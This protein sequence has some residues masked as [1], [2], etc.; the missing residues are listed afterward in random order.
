M[1][2]DS[3]TSAILQKAL[4]GTWQRQRAISN[5][6]ANHETPGYKAIKVDFENSLDQEIRKLGNSIPTKEKII[7]SIETLKDAEINVFSDNSTSNR[8]DGNNVDLDLENIEMAKMQIQ[9]QYL[10]RSM[11]DMFSRLRYAISEGKK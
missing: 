11:T 8:A 6:I 1:I 5:N 10:T 9:Y 2:G 7:E 3:I 4:D